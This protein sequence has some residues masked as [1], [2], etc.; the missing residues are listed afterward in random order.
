MVEAGVHGAMVAVQCSHC[1]TTDTLPAEA[2]ARVHALRL[3]LESLWWAKDTLYQQ[4]VHYCR[5]VEGVWISGTF[6]A[7]LGP[8][9][10][11]VALGGGMVASTGDP[12]AILFSLG[13]LAMLLTLV[14]GMMGG[15]LV[16]RRRYRECIR[17]WI[18]ARFPS[19]PGTPARCHCCGGGLPEIQDAF[20]TCT[21]CTATNLVPPMLADERRRSLEQETAVYRARA[22]GA[23]QS[24]AQQLVYM[25][26][27]IT[28]GYYIAF[29]GVLVVVLSGSVVMGM[30]LGAV[31]WS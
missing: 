21:Y 2:S 18:L 8:L 30:V 19:R 17:P 22:A 29:G 20:V 31:S 28:T 23:T 1:G 3:R 7:M 26:R 12:R 11:I 6:K 24:I 9:S 4:D 5:R 13:L 25:R 15:F 14:G 16:A 27:A 10:I